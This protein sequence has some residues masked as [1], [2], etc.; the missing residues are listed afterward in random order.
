MD[1]LQHHRE[2]IILASGIQQNSIRKGVTDAAVK[3]NREQQQT[4][5]QKG[6]GVMKLLHNARTFN[7]I[8][9]KRGEQKVKLKLLLRTVT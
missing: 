6:S 8:K 2:W 5:L 3:S 1:I 4:V 9:S 7:F